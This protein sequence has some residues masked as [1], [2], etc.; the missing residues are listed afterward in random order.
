MYSFSVDGVGCVEVIQL[1]PES[2]E[3]EFVGSV[4]STRS[5]DRRCSALWGN[6]RRSTLT[7]TTTVLLSGRWT[8]SALSSTR[9]N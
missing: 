9:T 7:V 1:Q 4:R 6:A 5:I 3:Y 2:N 8:L